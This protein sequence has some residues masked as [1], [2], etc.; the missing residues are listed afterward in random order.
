MAR[1]TSRGGRGPQPPARPEPPRPAAAPPVK[2]APPT[3]ARATGSLVL[4]A[5]GFAVMGAI[6]GAVTGYANWGE[7]PL[8][9]A[10]GLMAGLTGGAAAGHSLMLPI[11]YQV[12]VLAMVV[13]LDW[14]LFGLFSAHQAGPLGPV[15]GGGASLVLS[16][17]L[18]QRTEEE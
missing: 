13:V 10:A 5:V 12:I 17:F 6:G 8:A 11:R 18:S 7:S 3:P 1:R 14:L 2:P 4:T 15:I 16:W 9:A